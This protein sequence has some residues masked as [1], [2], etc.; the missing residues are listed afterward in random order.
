MEAIK[1]GVPCE[2]YSRVV[3]YYRPVKN[4]N[5]GQ[6]QQFKDRKTFKVVKNATNRQPKNF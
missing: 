2:I 6:R 4:W 5:E 1:M 3:G